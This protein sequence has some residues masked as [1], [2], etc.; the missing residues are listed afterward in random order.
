M[1]VYIDDIRDPHKYLTAEQAEGIV[2]LKEAWAARNFLI[3]HQAEI[4][5]LHLDNWLGDDYITGKDIFFMVAGECMWGG[6]EEFANVKQIYLH[7]S[8][9]DVVDE[10]IEEYAEK[11]SK[12]GVE[13][14]D[15]HN[16]Y[17][18]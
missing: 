5:V 9:T 8:D 10:L 7:S 17:N 11:L 12:V 16:E 2:W 14:I 18:H 15:N 6:R 4:E 1:K 3:E 13:L